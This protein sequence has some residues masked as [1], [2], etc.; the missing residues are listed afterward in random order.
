MARW[1]GGLLEFPMAFAGT[2]K[3]WMNG[4]M[5][6]WK[7]AT[8]HVA[9]HV[10]HYGTGAFEGLRAYDSRHGTNIFRLAPHMRRMIDS[11][12]V[13]RMEPK[14][15]Q[16]ELEQAV[17]DTVREERLVD[18]A[19][20][21]GAYFVEQLRKLA[22]R[23]PA[24]GNVRGLGLMIEVRVPEIELVAGLLVL[25]AHPRGDADDVVAP[26]FGADFLRRIG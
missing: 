17:I 5:V 7:D 2:G 13:Y 11:C 3:I 19:R 15:S 9:S 4:E 23:Q 1:P 16:A 18:R 8:I 21:S 12:K 25:E 6:D 26:A 24:L 10:I 14:W 20:E 22:D